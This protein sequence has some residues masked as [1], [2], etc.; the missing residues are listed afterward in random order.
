MAEGRLDVVWRGQCGGWVIETPDGEY[1]D[2]QALEASR[3]YLEFYGHDEH[4]DP[5]F[6]INDVCEHGT[7]L[8]EGCATC[9]EEFMVQQFAMCRFEDG[10]PVNEVVQFLVSMHGFT[11]IV[12]ASRIAELVA[13]VYANPDLHYHDT[14]A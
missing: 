4:S 10:K 12:P 14:V 5:P 2:H 6:E 8:I 3:Q 13:D 7:L 1:T 11:D 9:S